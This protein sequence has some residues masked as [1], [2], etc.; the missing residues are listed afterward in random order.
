MW[1]RDAGSPQADPPAGE[2]FPDLLE[3]APVMAILLDD[4]DQVVA[5]NKSARDFFKM[6]EARLPASLVEATLESRL[7]DVV[8]A[9]RPESEARLVHHRRT[10]LTRLVAGRR[11]GERVLFLT[12]VTELRRLATVR[13]E[14]VA[15]LVH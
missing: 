3:H 8:T 7:V 5:A 6:A 4:Q 14:F 15:N 10:V 2:R 9:G 13:Q 1:R 11:P 12:D